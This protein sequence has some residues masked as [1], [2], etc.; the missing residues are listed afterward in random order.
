MPNGARKALIASRPS[1]RRLSSAVRVQAIDAPWS[2]SSEGA[3]EMEPA[4]DHLEE[5]LEDLNVPPGFL[6]VAAPGVQA[7]P[8]DQEA[9]AQR[10]RGVGQ[11]QPHLPRQGRDVLCV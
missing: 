6:H 8:F 1:T 10:S 5:E 9:V 7:V 2:L 11:S 4:A 3:A